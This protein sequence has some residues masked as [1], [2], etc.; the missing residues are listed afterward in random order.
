MPADP[1]LDYAETLTAFAN[2][3]GGAFSIPTN[4]PAHTLELVLQAAL[5]STPPLVIPIPHVVRERGRTMLHVTIP[6]GLPHVYSVA[7]RYLIREGEVNQPLL[8]TRL[9][10]LLLERGEITFED[11]VVHAAGEADLDREAVEAY[12]ERLGVADVR[13]LLIR[14]GCLRVYD[15]EYK[16]TQAGIL[17]FGLDPVRFIR[18][19]FITAARFAG[20]EMGDIFTRIEIS[21]ALPDQIRR[22]ET[23]LIDHL[24]KD[25]QLTAAMERQERY[26]LP[27]EAAREALVNAVAHRDYSI[28]GDGIRLYLF[29]D[30]L[31]VTSPG[32]LPGPVTLSNLV[33]ERF[34]RNSIIVQVLADLGFIERL[35]YGIDRI[36]SLSRENSLPTP[37]FD[38]TRGGFRI[39]L[40]SNKPNLPPLASEYLEMGLN[41]RQQ[42]ALDFLQRNGTITNRQYQEL[43]PDVH[44]ETLR[45][46]LADLVAKD[47]IE[48]LGE[49]RGSYYVLVRK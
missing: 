36:L 48:R 39:T 41:P 10:R 18:G 28:Q 5:L 40:Y 37:E 30:R 8:P 47:L 32:K 17:L 6:P 31:E 20:L 43:C 23:F 46:D 38:E 16:P 29:A 3:R 33:E 13:E 9:R 14:R 44:S 24:R 7:G 1:V 49:K 35:G 27:L 11:E 34:S 19:A 21:G 45:R 15:G 22:A 25:V 12:A 2:G 4:Q 42:Q 26:E